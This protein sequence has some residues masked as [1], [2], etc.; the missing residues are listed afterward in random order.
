MQSM[1]D[2]GVGKTSIE[3][4]IQDEVLELFEEIDSKGENAFEFHGIFNKAVTNVICN[5]LFAKR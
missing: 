4:K 1:R 5:V 3:E 2:F